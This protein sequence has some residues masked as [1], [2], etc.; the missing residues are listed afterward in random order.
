ML[1]DIR[2]DPREESNL[3]DEEIDTRLRHSETFNQWRSD[4]EGYHA[5]TG[6][7]ST[8]VDM[9]DQ[10]ERHLEALGYLNNESE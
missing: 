3:F 2:V 7:E 4:C 5:G 8:Q 6:A 1:F 9:D 10:T